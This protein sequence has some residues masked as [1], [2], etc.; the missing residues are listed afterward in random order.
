VS[1]D[2]PWLHG[3][4]IGR[5]VELTAKL[6]APNSKQRGSVRIDSSRGSV[7]IVV[8]IYTS[9]SRPSPVVSFSKAKPVDLPNQ[10][11]A[12]TAVA[13]VLFAV[14][15]FALLAVLTM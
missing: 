1:C 4:T 12:I 6:R 3:E 2:V 5:S 11:D 8:D 13:V 9:P 7:T 15:V 10:L 14:A